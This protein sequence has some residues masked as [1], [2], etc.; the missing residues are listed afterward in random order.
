LVVEIY[1]TYGMIGVMTALVMAW[2]S[3]VN[4]W[5]A[6]ESEADRLEQQIL[7]EIEKVEAITKALEESSSSIVDAERT[8]QNGGLEAAPRGDP[9][10]DPAARE[11]CENY[12]K[13]LCDH[14]WPEDV[15]DNFYV[16]ECWV[17]GIRPLA[18]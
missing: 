2:V 15:A 3:G 1:A 5:K 6:M 12:Y 4:Q 17:R 9:G 14:G 10:E 18:P 16:V 13:S 7:A 11:H 8:L